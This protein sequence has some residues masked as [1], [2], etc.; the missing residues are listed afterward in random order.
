MIMSQIHYQM[1]EYTKMVSLINGIRMIG[2]IW[3]LL[4]TN[5]KMTS[6]FDWIQQ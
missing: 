4:F 3:V 5:N 6:V 2:G 1:K